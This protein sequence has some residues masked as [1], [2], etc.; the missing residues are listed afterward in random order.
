[1]IK[2]THKNKGV[3]KM[4]TDKIYAQSIVNEYSVKQTSKAIALRKLDKK[5]KQPSNIFAYI[6]GSVFALILGIGMCLS[7]QVIGSGTNMFIIG[8]VIGL[9]G[10]IGCSINYPIYK[11]IRKKSMAK[12]ADDIL[13]LAQDVAEQ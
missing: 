3:L 13:L 9:L 8:I 2:L 4:N 10:I 6:F 7:M 5:A 1:M 12:Y 11:L